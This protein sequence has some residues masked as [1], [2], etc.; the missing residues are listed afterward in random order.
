MTAVAIA[1]AGVMGLTAA[2]ALRR[3]GHP[4]T[5]VDPGPVPHPEAAST[6]VSKMVRLEYGSDARYVEMMEAALPR[7]RSWPEF[8]ETGVSFL[9]RAP[10]ADDSFEATSARLLA[11][12]G[13]PV[14]RLD[15]A[16]I[17]TLGWRRLVDG[18]H[19]PQGGW[20]ESAAVVARL[21][22]EATTLGVTLRLEPARYDGTLTTP[23]GPIA[24]DVTL[25]A[26]GAWTPTLVP[27]LTDRLSSVG[28][29][30]LHLRPLDP[31][32]FRAPF[33]PFG[34][35]IAETGWYGFPARDGVVKLAHHGAGYPGAPGTVPFPAEAETAARAL[36]RRHLPALADAPAV[37]RRVC[38]YCDSFD[39]DFFIGRSP[40]DPHLVV[41][42]GGSGHAFKFAPVLG[43][44]IADV[45]DDRDHPW[46]PRFAWRDEPHGTREGARATT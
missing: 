31:E 25:I 29:P 27:A 17:T 37:H 42:A 18:H 8:H 7:W 12:R 32:P 28:Q 9:T 3:R 14:E 15:E 23:S 24:A 2:I 10:R 35:D 1:G 40:T 20:A 39:G 19:N 34:V 30:I 16:A 36:L 4:V 46:A 43:E 13:H 26:A 6:D 38:H 45:V 44:L 21:R 33:L 11:A 22:D 41:A 5:L